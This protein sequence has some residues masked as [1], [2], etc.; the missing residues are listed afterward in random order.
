[1]ENQKNQ[2]EP[3]VGDKIYVPSSY[4]VYRGQDDFDGGIATINKVK[5]SE[6]LPKD[7]FNYWMVGIAERETVMYNWRWLMEQ[8]EELKE[9]YLDKVA[10]PNPD[11][12]AEFN[13]PDADWI[14]Y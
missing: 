14:N 3:K 8:Q 11:D 13:Q 6:H 1:M 4:Y 7:H 10:S 12:R 2:I 9:E 5:A